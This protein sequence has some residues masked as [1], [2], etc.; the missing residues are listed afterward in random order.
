MTSLVQIFMYNR[1][2]T[3]L[4]IYFNLLVFIDIFIIIKS[5]TIF[6]LKLELTLNRERSVYKRSNK[7]VLLHIK[8]RNFA[9]KT[10]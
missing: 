5:K 10:Q 8:I 9:R 3:I 2:P 7:V 4:V 6:K 1:K